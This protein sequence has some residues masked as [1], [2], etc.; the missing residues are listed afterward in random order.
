MSSNDV[1]GFTPENRDEL[2]MGCWSEHDDGSLLYVYSTEGDRVVYT[3]FDVSK[4]PIVE[5]RDAMPI[6][7]FKVN[8]SWSA[9]KRRR[10]SLQAIKWTWHD[11]TPF[12]WDRIIKAG[13]G[14]GVKFASAGDI[15]TAAER[16]AQS[17]KLRGKNVIAST[18]AGMKE[19]TGR[20]G[21]L[22]YDKIKRALGELRK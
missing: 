12:P 4:D 15:L 5:Y 17:L 20:R 8:F 22:I 10:N 9:G 6:G 18:Y 16:V 14:D 1:P 21:T 2:A 3:M 11:K 7:G 13:A 19:E